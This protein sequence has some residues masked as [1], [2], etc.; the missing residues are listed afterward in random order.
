MRSYQIK[1]EI[2]ALEQEITELEVK[3]ND[4]S[5]FVEFLKT[6]NSFEEQ[7]RLKLGLKKP[8]EKM[9]VI[10]DEPPNEEPG[11]FEEPSYSYK[12]EEGASNPVLWWRY[13]F[14]S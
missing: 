4:F 6:E 10:T 2:Q 11:L 7:A 12:Q 3:T 1:Q 5:R 14:Q 8:G 13:F 9:I